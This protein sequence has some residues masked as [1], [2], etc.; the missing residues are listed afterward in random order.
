VSNPTP[1]DVVNV[2]I[3]A[4]KHRGGMTKRLIE[5]SDAARKKIF[6]EWDGKD[7]DNKP[8]I[9]TAEVSAP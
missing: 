2:V 8:Q 5:I 9:R 7:N 1:Q 4:I 6:P 3:E